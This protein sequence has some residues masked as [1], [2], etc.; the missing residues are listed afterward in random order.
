MVTC[1]QRV[2]TPSQ[3]E[4]PMRADGMAV[5]SLICLSPAVKAV[6]VILRLEVEAAVSGYDRPWVAGP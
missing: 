6:P 3:G 4:K 5:G 1:G 2:T